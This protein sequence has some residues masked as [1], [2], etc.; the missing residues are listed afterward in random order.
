MD[1]SPLADGDFILLHGRL[2]EQGTTGSGPVNAFAADEL[3]S[4]RLVWRGVVTDEPVR[5]LS[6][7]LDLVRHHPQPV[8]LQ[9]DLKPYA[10][11]SAGDLSRLVEALQPLKDRV[12]VTS[13]ADW[14]LRRLHAL[15]AGLPLGFDPLLYL[16]ADAR[17]TRD[18]MISPFRLGA[19]NYWDDH[20]L[21]S[22]RWGTAADY[23]ATRAEALWVQAPAGALWYIA[24]PLLAQALDDG[25]DWIA[26]LH[27]RGVQVA[28]WT[29]DAS[30]AEQAALARR[31]AALG[32]DRII[33][34]DAPALAQVLDAGVVY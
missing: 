30:H 8:E 1:I 7:A 17:R 24:A 32:V 3:A 5:P 6:W 20:P 23:L 9:L 19:Y 25:F 16:D 10:P 26:D 14:V 13:V 33:T 18:P 31:L 27:S 11:F 34:N 21:A 28:A 22:R 12:R 15:D 2:L 29:L 4:L